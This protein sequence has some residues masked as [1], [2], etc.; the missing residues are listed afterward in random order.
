MPQS[1][2]PTG[3]TDARR[4]AASRASASAGSHIRAFNSQGVVAVKNREVSPSDVKRVI[5]AAKAVSIPMDRE[6]IHVVPRY[7]GDGLQLPWVQLSHPVVGRER[8]ARVV[9]RPVVN[10][11][12]T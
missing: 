8:R 3:P 12:Q 7:E 4:R 9:A 11:S 5:D 2:Q 10:L 1:P 6:V